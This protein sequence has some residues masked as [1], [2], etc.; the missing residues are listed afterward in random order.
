MN[1]PKFKAGDLVRLQQS[2]A[3]P[4]DPDKTYEVLDT[5]TDQDGKV[6]HQLKGL[7]HCNGWCLEDVLR[8]GKPLAFV[9]DIDG[10]AADCSHRVHLV[11]KVYDH[12]E[13][14]NGPKP[15]WKAFYEAAE[16]DPPVRACQV[17]VRGLIA[18]GITPIFL[19]GRPW[20]YMKQT[21]GWLT[22]HN[23]I[24]W[25]G[26]DSVNTHLYMRPDGD[27]CPDHELK[28]RVYRET[29]EPEWDVVVWLE[30]RD[31][32]VRMVREDLGLQCWQ[33]RK[34]DF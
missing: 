23:F 17:V 32:V 5:R 27:H 19:T 10:T 3:D 12:I 33:V 24:T 30:D 18:Q 31:S 13:N 6:K 20:E 21:R 16:K 4:R 28:A 7:M 9:C 15:D 11:R 2:L 8:N 29:I 26:E 25:A 34:G 1:G 22:K 14:G